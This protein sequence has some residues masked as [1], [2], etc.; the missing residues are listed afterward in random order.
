MTSTR[1]EQPPSLGEL[2]SHRDV[3]LDI[4]RRHGVHAIR[5]FGSVARGDAH[6]GSDVDLLVELEP[7]RSL[8]DL[9]GLLMDLRDLLG[10]SVD[11]VTPAALQQ[12]IRTAVMREAVP[13]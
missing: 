2:R 7:G 4:A 10:G 3:I 13:L 9:G 5:V 8:F 6:R 12:R 11:V 1:R